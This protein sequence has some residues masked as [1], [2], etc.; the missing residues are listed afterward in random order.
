MMVAAHLHD[1]QIRITKIKHIKKKLVVPINSVTGIT[2]LVEDT[3]FQRGRRHCM[4]IAGYCVFSCH[5]KL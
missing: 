4:I 1:L 2:K 3:A 5:K